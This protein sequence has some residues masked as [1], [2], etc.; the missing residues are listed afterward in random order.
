[1]RRLLLL[2]CA[3]LLA[4]CATMSEVPATTAGPLDSTFRANGLSTGKIKIT[5]PVTFQVGGTGNMAAPSA[6]D[7]RKAGQRHGSAATAPHAT[8]STTTKEAG[9]AWYWFAL[10][11]VC[12]IAAWEYLSSKFAPLKWLPWRSSS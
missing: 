6:T 10:V 3:S 11:G 4:S 9:T 7:N 2:A 1:M 8:A 5:G 12:C